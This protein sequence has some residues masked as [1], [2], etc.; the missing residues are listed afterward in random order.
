MTG[1]R[2]L[3]VLA[4]VLAALLVAIPVFGADP[5]ASPGASDA[6][7][8]APSSTT[9]TDPVPVEPT[10]DDS[11]GAPAATPGTTPSFDA[12][13]NPD[14]APSAQDPADEDGK[15]G[16]GPKDKK[17]KGPEVAITVTGTVQQA[18]DGQG[19]PTFTLMAGGTTWELSAGPKWFWGAENPLAAYVGKSVTVVGTSHAGAAEPEIDVETVDGTAIRAAGK[20]PW[21][22]GPWVVGESHPGWKPWKTDGKPGRGLGREH[23][24]GQL[25]KQTTAS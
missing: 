11:L 7:S 8:A 2:R 4:G 5:S 3:V 25:K 24:P 1:R 12:A 22:G 23:A 18:T 16:K 20:P 21:A 13:P 9:P 17:D 10:P 19:R 6:A 15:P 14:A